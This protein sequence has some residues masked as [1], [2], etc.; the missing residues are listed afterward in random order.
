MDI[1]KVIYALYVQIVSHYHL[2]N[3]YIPT[4]YIYYYSYIGTEVAHS[5]N[6]Y[7]FEHALSQYYIE[8]LMLQ[9]VLD[10]LRYFLHCLVSSFPLLHFYDYI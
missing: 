10:M 8:M 4:R 2:H 1:D 3:M 7:M 9:T 6:P 5:K